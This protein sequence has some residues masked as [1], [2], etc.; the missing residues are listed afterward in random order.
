[1]VHADFAADTAVLISLND[2]LGDN[3]TLHPPY[4]S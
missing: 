4:T 3:I 1:L 2:V